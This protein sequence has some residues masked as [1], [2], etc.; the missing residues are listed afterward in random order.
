[1]GSSYWVSVKRDLSRDCAIEWL[2]PGDCGCN[3]GNY[4]KYIF[5]LNSCQIS[6]TNNMKFSCL[7]I[8]KF[9]TKHGS[10]TAVLCDKFQNDWT[11]EKIDVEEQDF[12]IF[13]FTMNFGQNSNIAMTSR[14]CLEIALGIWLPVSHAPSCIGTTN[15]SR[16][17]LNPLSLLIFSNVN[18]KMA[19]RQ[20]YWNFW[21]PDSNFSL[22]LNINCELKWHS[23]YIYMGRSLL[24]F[25]DVTFKIA[26]WRPYWIFWFPD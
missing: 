5:K 19:A 6:F 20:P 3:S 9:V 25:S 1:M 7:I 18:F 11:T 24:I 14:I 17:G 8:L 12:M 13:W 22:A 23:T 26:A 10:D 2:V 4:H 21:F 16:T 15:P